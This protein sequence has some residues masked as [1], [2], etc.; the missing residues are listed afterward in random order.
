MQPSSFVLQVP[1]NVQRSLL[2]NLMYSYPNYTWSASY[3]SNR[4]IK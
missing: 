1:A 2:L 4:C 3:E